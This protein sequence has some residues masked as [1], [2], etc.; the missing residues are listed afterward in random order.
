MCTRQISH[1]FR[2]PTPCLSLIY[3]FQYM[4][5]IGALHKSLLQ[6]FGKLL[7]SNPTMLLMQLMLQP[8]NQSSS[9]YCIYG[10]DLPC[11]VHNIIQIH[12][13]VM[14]NIL[15]FNLNMG[16][17]CII[18]SIPH[19]I[20]MDLNNV[21]YSCP[22]K[23]CYISHGKH[24]STLSVEPYYNIIQPNIFAKQGQ[25]Y[26]SRGPQILPCKFRN[27]HVHLEKL[28]ML[29]ESQNNGHTLILLSL[30]NYPSP[31][32]PPPC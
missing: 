26:V 14:W 16:I 18:L 7:S 28:V 2:N 8:I 5:S 17:F 9:A 11:V 23:P 10:I 25:E 15:I 4:I 29:V 20:V 22:S 19:N 30:R 31:I 6:L 24:F 1:E 32:I 13:N 21:M 12:N 27:L 3:S